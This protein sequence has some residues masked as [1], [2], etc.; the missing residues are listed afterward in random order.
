MNGKMSELDKV[1]V[2]TLNF[3]ASIVGEDNTNR[4]GGDNS[5]ISDQVSTI[6]KCSKLS[7]EDFV[8]S[9]F[10]VEGGFIPHFPP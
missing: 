6:M 7:N 4:F 5:S 1:N 10:I 2:T 8:T 3:S 9:S